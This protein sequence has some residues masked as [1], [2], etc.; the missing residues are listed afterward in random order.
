MPFIYKYDQIKEENKSYLCVGLDSDIS[1]IPSF[2]KSEKD[3]ILTFNKRIIDET[4]KY[5]AA[6]KPNFAFYIAQGVNGIETLKKT[7]DYIPDNIIKIVDIKAGDIGN[8][9]EQYTFSVFEYFNADAMTI[10]VLMG[11]DV[12]NS[13]LKIDNAFA[14]ALAITSNDTAEQYFMHYDLY[15]KIGSMIKDVGAERLGAVVGATRS[16][17]LA[18]M[19]ELMPETVF[20]IPG[21][22]AQGGDLEQVC[23]YAKYKSDDARFLISSSRG[24]IFADNT[25]EF[26]RVA[27]KEA[28]KLRDSIKLLLENDNS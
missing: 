23:K 11:S 2:L 6:Y 24:I 17:D 16:E 9:M 8:T 20:L 15:K 5:T 1:K 28:E 14:F 21:I 7:L 19:R 18:T 25:Q 4:Y 26:A 27:G 3:P 10:N 13:Y 22:G 12:I